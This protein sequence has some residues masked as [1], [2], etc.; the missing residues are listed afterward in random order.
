MQENG[1][2]AIHLLGQ[3]IRRAG[4]AGCLPLNNLE[5]LQ[6]TAAPM[7]A[8]FTEATRIAG[9][10]QYQSTSPLPLQQTIARNAVSGSDILLVQSML[11]DNILV[12]AAQVETISL[13]DKP[14]YRKDDSLIIADCTH[15]NLV[16]VTAVSGKQIAIK[17]ALVQPYGS[18]A[19]I[20]RLTSVFYYI[21]KTTRKNSAGTPVYALY[22]RDI[23]QPAVLAQELVEGVEQMQIKFGVVHKD[24][25]DYWPISKLTRHDWPR[26]A[27]VQIAL[28]LDSIEPVTDGPAH[29]SF[30]QK[31]YSS[32]DR[33]L[34]QEWS[35]VI[36]VREPVTG[37]DE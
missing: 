17:P 9:W 27:S 28:L 22:R 34:R 13:S 37:D 24:T 20:G 10:H 15:A 19:Q 2:T 33:L 35:V 6:A 18:T 5:A 7:D 26:I 32:T 29:F 8:N 23:N 25:I 30:D 16:Q 14:D 31:I 3:D 36:A 1:R 4:Y 12:K 21:R 11:P